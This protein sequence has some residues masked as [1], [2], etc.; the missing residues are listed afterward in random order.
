MRLRQT[1]AIALLVFTCAASPALAQRVVTGEGAISDSASGLCLDSDVAAGDGCEVIVRHDGTLSTGGTLVP[2]TRASA[3][4]V[5]A[6]ELSQTNTTS[7]AFALTLPS[8]PADGSVYCAVDQT[9]T[10]DTNNLTVQRGG[11]DTVEGG[12]ST[13]LGVEWGQACFY[14]DSATTRWIAE[15]EGTGGGGGAAL[16]LDQTAGETDLRY[17]PTPEVYYF[18]EDGSGT[19]DDGEKKWPQQV[20]YAVD[21]QSGSTTTAGIQEA[22]TAACASFPSSPY[23]AKVVIPDGNVATTGTVTIPCEWVTLEGSGLGSRWIPAAGTTALIV[24]DDQITL[25]DF[26]IDFTSA[27]AANIGIDAD[28]G[29]T[30]PAALRIH[31]VTLRGQTETGVGFRCDACLKTHISDSVIQDWGQGTVWTGTVG[32]S[33]PNAN[34]IVSTTISQN[35]GEAV[36]IEDAHST[37][38]ISSSTFESNDIGIRCDTVANG[39]AVLNSISNHFEAHD[40]AGIYRPDLG[41]AINSYGDRF[42]DS[43]AK[44]YVS[45]D[46]TSTKPTTFYGTQFST[47]GITN[48]TG[49]AARVVMPVH[50]NGLSCGG[51]T[52]SCQ[53]WDE[54]TIGHLGQTATIAGNWDN[55]ANP[56]ADNEVANDLTIAAVAEIGVDALGLEFEPGDALT[57]CSTFSATGGGIFYDDSEG[58]LKKCQDNTLTDLDTGGGSGDPILVNGA[59]VA[60]GAGVD[61][62]TGL[63]VKVTLATGASPDSATFDLLYTSTLAG[64]LGLGAGECV[65]TVN[66]GT[67]GGFLCEGPTANTNEQ[68]YSFPNVDGADTTSFFAMDATSITDLD[69]VGLGI[70]SAALRVDL[71]E[72]TLSNGLVASAFNTMAWGSLSGADLTVT[73]GNS[74]SDIN[75][76]FHNAGSAGVT[77]GTERVSGQVQRLRV[78]EDPANGNNYHGF[79]APSAIGSDQEPDLSAEFLTFLGAPSSANLAAWLTGETGTGGVVFDTSPTIATPVLT[80]KIDRNNVAVDDDDCTGDQGNSWYDSVDSRHEFCDLNSGTPTVLGG[81]S[82]LGDPGGNGVVVRT[83]L[84]TTTNR[85]LASGNTTH[86]TWA[87]GDGVSGNPTITPTA[88]ARTRSCMVPV[89]A[90]SSGATTHVDLWARCGIPDASTLT[91]VQCSTGQANGFSILLYER[92]ETAPTTGTTDMLGGALACDSDGAVDTS[93]S[94]SAIA[95]DSHL[96]IDITSESLAA[97]EGGWIQIEWT[98]N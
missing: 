54:T 93:F 27:N 60:D 24:A 74:A 33:Y 84:N 97:G 80:G 88:T 46:T 14:Y 20:L 6:G 72:L 92:A 30:G 41:C 11:S 45:V 65:L 19:H 43:N 15:V 36:Y 89:L 29:G 10:W 83:A 56:W 81:G 26:V 85:T 40:T 98:V 35:A 8:A 31:G 67:V 90:D 4:T 94:D 12:T 25:R 39:Y 87:D 75:I 3:G 23:G 53:I 55:T 48:A 51:P 78:Y 18:D 82:G 13:V 58:K 91:K 42:S 38:N 64:N 5:A 1:L 37:F 32:T 16:A 69:G 95:A 52:S 86:L 68:F 44:D 62:L 17:L 47:S 79:K 63:G 77:F 21:Y 9:G 96:V 50:E 49:I 71:T 76:I 22:V 70:N 57:D 66:G 34:S 28:S 73:V 59:A 2:V 7:A 61:L